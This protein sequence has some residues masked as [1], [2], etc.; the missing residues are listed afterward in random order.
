MHVRVVITPGAKRELVSKVKDTEFHISVRE[1]AERNM[2]NHRVREL[3][4][5][6]F[7]VSVTKVRLL[8]GHRSR[9]KIVDVE[10]YQ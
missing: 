5:E 2:A 8:T 4:A 1:P 7:G 10:V 3:V 9:A 6:E